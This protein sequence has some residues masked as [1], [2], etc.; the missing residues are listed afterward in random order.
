MASPPKTGSGDWRE[1]IPGLILL[2]TFR[3]AKELPK[4]LL[5]ALGLV[6]T[7]AGWRVAAAVFSGDPAAQASAQPLRA[8]PW[9]GSPPSSAAQ[10]LSGRAHWVAERLGL[11]ES[12]DAADWTWLARNPVADTWE[13]ICRPARA[14]IGGAAG[15]SELALL[16]V[17]ALWAVAVWAVVGGA[18]ARIAAIQICREE[19]LGLLEGWSFAKRK[20]TD[21]VWAP[22]LPLGLIALMVV[23][24]SLGSWLMRFDLGLLLI[25][26]GF[27]LV[28]ISGFVVATVSLG[29]ALGW[30]LMWATVCVEGTDHFDAISR[31]YAYVFQRP[32]EYLGYWLA[33]MAYGVLCWLVVAAVAAASVLLGL[34]ASGWTIGHDRLA[35]WTAAVPAEVGM[36]NWPGPNRGIDWPRL[37]AAS[38]AAAELPGDSQ[39]SVAGGAP[40][41]SAPGRLAVLLVAFWIGAV[42]LLAL[43]FGPSF[44]WTSAVAVYLL[45]RRS[46]DHAE[47]DEVYVDPQQV[48][49]GLPKLATDAAGVPVVAEE[50]PA[51]TAQPLTESQLNC[52]ALIEP[53]IEVGAADSEAA[54]TGSTTSREERADNDGG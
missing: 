27:P 4:L 35:T 21:L 48:A 49:Y 3:L 30:P 40:R 11:G 24:V 26:A 7:T 13:L 10:A 17:A 14:L 54:L 32:L 36:V 23:V 31:A 25:A 6:A 28:I 12:L 20:W 45:M 46:T 16:L 41:L 19:R 34:W 5:G 51:G 43:G 42:K 15:V 39:P 38:N 53:T 37:E 50:T 2:R 1:M 9:Q 52:T 29:L 33:A 44:F 22:L 18:I 47:L 8:W